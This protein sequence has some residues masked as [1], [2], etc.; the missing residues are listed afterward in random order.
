MFVKYYFD[1]E[2][3]FE[4]IVICMLGF[5]VNFVRNMWCDM[6]YVNMWFM[7]WVY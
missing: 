1:E 4:V 5:L 2:C 3:Y 6:W 7:I